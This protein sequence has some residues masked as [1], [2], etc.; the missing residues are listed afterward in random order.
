[1][2]KMNEI[3]RLLEEGDKEAL[4]DFFLDKGFKGSAATI[5]VREFEKAYSELN[6]KGENND[7]I[8][9]KRSNIN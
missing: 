7:K 8:N 2:G 1:M 4:E 3:F 6:N 9:T 5:A